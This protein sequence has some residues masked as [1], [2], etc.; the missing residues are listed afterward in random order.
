MELLIF[1]IPITILL[2]IAILLL[3]PVSLR[4][5]SRGGFLKVE[6]AG[7]PFTREFG[8]KKPRRPEEK[9]KKGGARALKAFGQVLLRDR[10]LLLKLSQE[11]YRLTVDV[12]R[13]FSIRE[14]EAN[15]STP[16]PAWNG[17]LWGIFS[18]INLK[19]VTLTVNF[20]NINH[21]KGWLQFYPYKVLGVISGL[22]VRLPY[23]RII[24]AILSSKRKHRKE[25]SSWQTF[26]K[27][28]S[29]LC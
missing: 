27:A 22:L 3:L 23:R 2:G 12:L 24:R 15:V 18:S 29:K 14:L 11:G 17:V 9:P 13:S 16:D 6:W 25:G 21:V 1:V 10:Y 26:Q 20:Q 4:F 8:R 7:V 5:D 28:L 19:N